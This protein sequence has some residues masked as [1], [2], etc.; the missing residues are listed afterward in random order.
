MLLYKN[1]GA[2][3]KKKISFFPWR[4]A[5]GW[6]VSVVPTDSSYLLYACHADGIRDGKGGLYST[7]NSDDLFLSVKEGANDWNCPGR[8]KGGIIF[9]GDVIGSR[10]GFKAIFGYCHPLS[11]ENWK[12][13]SWLGPFGWLRRQAPFLKELGLRQILSFFLLQNFKK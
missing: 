2:F 6:F 3:F 9:D 7:T 12:I 10:V 13:L 1:T 8:R 11:G 4:L 5:F